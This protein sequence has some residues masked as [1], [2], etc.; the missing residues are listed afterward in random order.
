MV[1][2]TRW[3]AL[4]RLGEGE[5]HLIIPYQR[6]RRAHAGVLDSIWPSCTL[7]LPCAVKF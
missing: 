3:I 6:H 4:Q 5:D 7:S 2:E 1:T